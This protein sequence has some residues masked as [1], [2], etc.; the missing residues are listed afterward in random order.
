MD[1]VTSLNM[2]IC[3]V[4]LLLLYVVENHNTIKKTPTFVSKLRIYNK[5]AKKQK[6]NMA[7]AFGLPIVHWWEGQRATVHSL[8]GWRRQWDLVVVRAAQRPALIDHGP[9][10]VIMVTSSTGRVPCSHL[11]G[12]DTGWWARVCVGVAS[13]VHGVGVMVQIWT[14]TPDGG[15]RKEEEEGVEGEVR[16]Y[17]NV[18]IIQHVFSL[19]VCYQT[20]IMQT[21][22]FLIKMMKKHK[23]TSVCVH[24]PVLW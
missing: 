4:L 7:L 12:Q 11:G 3:Y 9:A 19:R 16:K 8:S 2:S 15:S 13:M 20:E 21:Y 10:P 17:E 6:I 23:H 5:T 1:T 18:G 24:L 14:M 22:M